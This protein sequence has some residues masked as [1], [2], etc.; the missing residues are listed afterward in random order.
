MIAA[1]APWAHRAT[2]KPAVLGA[3]AHVAEVM[4]KIVIPIVRARLA[5]IRSDRLPAKSSRAANRSV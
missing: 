4:V 2:I 5:P 3:S 1:P